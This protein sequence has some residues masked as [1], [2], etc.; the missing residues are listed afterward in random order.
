MAALGAIVLAFSLSFSGHAIAAPRLKPLAVLADSLHVLGASSWLGSLAVVLL[1][2][3]PLAGRLAGSQR[4]P[5][6]A[7][8]INA[9]SPVALTSAAL[10]ASTGLFAAWLHVGRIPNLWGTRYGITLLIKLAILGIVSITG[11]YNWRVVKPTL[12]TPEASVH[13]GRSARV[14]VVVALLV[15]L[16]TAILVATPTSMDM[17]P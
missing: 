13:L 2:G 16:V 7:Q 9:F 8:L 3:L 10:A 6:V 14:E 4:G 17:E 5:L 15:L 11:F 1:V 12:G